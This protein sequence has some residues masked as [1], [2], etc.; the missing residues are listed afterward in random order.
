MNIVVRFIL[1]CCALLV[2]CC[3]AFNGPVNLDAV[4]P[5]RPLTPQEVDDY[6][7]AWRSRFIDVPK[8]PA[9]SDIER[10]QVFERNLLEIQQHNANPDRTYTAGINA[11]TGLTEDE[12]NQR[13]S[14]NLEQLANTA[15]KKR[16]TPSPSI[17]NRPF[18]QYPPTNFDWRTY[19]GVTPV[20]DQQSCGS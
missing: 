10:R 5:N 13:L 6:F 8:S 19:G 12:R 20:K 7:Q 11:F 14:P 15:H 3:V 4:I 1:F 17:F 2:P 16:Q 18:V 9:I